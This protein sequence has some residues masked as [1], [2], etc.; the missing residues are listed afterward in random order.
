M[1]KHKLPLNTSE[2]ISQMGLISETGS[3]HFSL[4]DQE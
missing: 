1:G 4:L 2:T 3:N